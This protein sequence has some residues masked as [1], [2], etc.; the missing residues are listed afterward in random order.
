MD[1]TGS[2]HIL[3]LTP[4][5][6]VPGPLNIVAKEG[7]RVEVK[8]LVFPGVSASLDIKASLV[9]KG[10]SFDLSGFYLCG[11]D[12]DFSLRTEVSHLV[13]GC[14]SNQLFN[15]AAAGSAKVTFYGRI[16]VA[17]DA[18]GTEAYQT[19][20]N[21]L[22]SDTAVIDT[23]PQL[24][25]YADDVKCSHGAAIGKLDDLELFYMRSRGIPLQEAK[26]MQLYSFLSP[27]LAGLPEEYSSR[28]EEALRAIVL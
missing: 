15:G 11:A 8:L 21:I 3:V 24:E 7:E 1:L 9:G 26:I 4:G 12:E 5:F 25:I 14:S 17:Q 28:L 13:P 22:L 2:S 20:R 19:N 10:A 27:A 23:K 16:L 6:A 18:I